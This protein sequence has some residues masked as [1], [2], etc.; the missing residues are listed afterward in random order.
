MET[1]IEKPQKKKKKKKDFRQI[2][3]NSERE[4]TNPGRYPEGPKRYPKT[5]SLCS[6][7]PGKN[8]A[9]LEP[10][11]IIDTLPLAVFFLSFLLI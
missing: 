10:G 1:K 9:E 5:P 2:L 8:P 11:N 4:P 3:P 6:L 7:S